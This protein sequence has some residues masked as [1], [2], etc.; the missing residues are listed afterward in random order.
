MSF[1]DTLKYDGKGLIPAIIQDAGS[2]EVLMFAFTNSTALKK[3][4]KT[5]FMHFYSRSRN[6]LWMK[7]E[8]SGNVQKVKK[9]YVDC[10]ADT[11][12]VLVEPKGAA[13]HNGYNSCFYRTEK[14]K[15]ILK[16]VFDPKKVY[17]K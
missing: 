10:D 2:G 1:V 6:K 16:K 11:I 8:E 9:I 13:C 14:G 4:L 5:G 12:L 3:T 15:I 17:R 7:G